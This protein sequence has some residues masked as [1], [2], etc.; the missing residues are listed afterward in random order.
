MTQD[1]SLG[2]THESH[3]AAWRTCWNFLVGQHPTAIRP[4]G[5]MG[6][7]PALRPAPTAGEQSAVASGGGTLVHL[8]S[9]RSVTQPQK[10]L[11]VTLP[12]NP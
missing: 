7:Q 3:I 11:W 4:M 12:P 1:L 5:A 9:C 6:S 10:E 2:Q 8:N